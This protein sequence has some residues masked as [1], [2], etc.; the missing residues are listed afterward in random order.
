MH[1][2]RLPGLQG[3]LGSTGIRPSRPGRAAVVWQTWASGRR[4]KSWAEEDGKLDPEQLSNL[5]PPA[6]TSVHLPTTMARLS[7]RLL[8]AKS[9]LAKAL[10][11]RAGKLMKEQEA[12][13]DSSYARPG[14][15]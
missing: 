4:K 13:S 15:T 12:F 11:D 2:Y 3:L 9:C 5:K 6:P 10:K 1:R 14:P 7:S 8:F